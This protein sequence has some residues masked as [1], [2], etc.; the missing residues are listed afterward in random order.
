MVVDQNKCIGCGLCR[1]YCPTQAISIQNK[2]AYID[3]DL[4][5][6]CGNCRFSGICRKEALVQQTMV[7]PRL[8][9]AIFSNVREV[10]PNTG[11][12]GRGTEEMK[13]NDVTGRFPAGTVGFACEMGRPSTGSTLSDL[14]TIADVFVKHG[15]RLETENPTA[16]IFEESRPGKVRKEFLNERVLSAIIEGLLDPAELPGLL[17]DLKEAQKKVDTVFSVDLIVR[18]ENGRNPVT[19]LL[20]RAGVEPRPNGKT[21]IGLGHVKED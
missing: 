3:L 12:N 18:L 19:P 4:C 11:I 5:V 6:E 1:P 8:I 2:K 20:E 16:L 17:Q 9:R 10:S 21:C 14:Q 7:M 13:T 15:A